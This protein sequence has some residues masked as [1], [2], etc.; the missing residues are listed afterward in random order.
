MANA[1]ITD[2]VVGYWSSGRT[3]T[4]EM[5]EQAMKEWKAQGVS[6]A[7]I[8][9]T[10]MSAYG[11]HQYQQRSEAALA[12]DAKRPQ[13]VA[14][15]RAQ[16]YD[17]A[18]INDMLERQELQEVRGISGEE[19]ERLAQASQPQKDPRAI[20]NETARL[21]AMQEA[22]RVKET[23]TEAYKQIYTKEYREKISPRVKKVS[24]K[25][26]AKA[27]DKLITG[28]LSPAQKEEILKEARLIDQGETARAMG[29]PLAA[30]QARWNE[31]KDNSPGYEA[32]AREQIIQL[33]QTGKAYFPGIGDIQLKGTQQPTPTQTITGANLF[34]QMPSQQETARA[35]AAEFIK[36]KKLV[37]GLSTP[38]GYEAITQK[39]ITQ[40]IPREPRTYSQ[41]VIEA[42]AKIEDVEE[43]FKRSVGIPQ[44]GFYPIKGI[45]ESAEKL[46]TFG[47]ETG[48]RL[49]GQFPSPEVSVKTH[50]IEGALTAPQALLELPKF[51]AKT[52]IAD[53]GIR[54]LQKRADAGD[55]KARLELEKGAYS[56]ATQVISTATDPSFYLQTAGMVLLPAVAGKAA[57]RAIRSTA[58][59]GA[60]IITKAGK[61]KVKITPVSELNTATLS[62]IVAEQKIP[63]SKAVKLTA[64]QMRGLEVLSAETKPT[65]ASVEALLTGKAEFATKTYPRIQIGNRVIDL[66][67]LAETKSYKLSD[68]DAIG[69]TFK[70]YQLQRE[71]YGVGEPSLVEGTI[72]SKG[73][74][75]EIIEPYA[76]KEGAKTGKY[77]ARLEKPLE[78]DITGRK[79]KQQFKLPSQRNIDQLLKPETPYRITAEM[80]PQEA[81]ASSQ[82][83]PRSKFLGGKRYVRTISGKTRPTFTEEILGDLAIKKIGGEA[84]L[85]YESTMPETMI[86][87]RIIKGKTT[88]VIKGRAGSLDIGGEIIKKIFPDA[89]ISKPWVEVRKPK[90]FKKPMKP[91]DFGKGTKQIEI[92]K[93]D[94]KDILGTTAKQVETIAKEKAL[95][96]KPA[97]QKTIE[98]ISTRAK[99]GGRNILNDINMAYTQLSGKAIPTRKGYQP[100][101]MRMA[102]PTTIILPSSKDIQILK[103]SQ[104]T[105][106][107]QKQKGTQIQ[108]QPQ[109]KTQLSRQR[110][111]ITEQEKTLQTIIG[112]N[113]IRQT[114][115]P[116]DEEPPA[117]EPP[118]PPIL[119]VL[120]PSL[121]FGFGPSKRSSKTPSGKAKRT[122]TPDLTSVIKNIKIPSIKTSRVLSGVGIRGIYEPKKKRVKRGARN[123]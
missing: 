11:Q 100:T 15:L 29:V 108:R 123:R 70:K 53:A 32:K 101:N 98:K 18:Q 57:P 43:R 92:T 14:E 9:Q 47:Q 28:D 93:T 2:V 56:S 114:S 90:Q 46:A 118:P 78:F 35:E 24:Y 97:Y 112:T 13:L 26:Q 21:E 119:P 89:P 83:S 116:P 40:P 66:K 37:Y 33:E 12:W 110:Q 73:T 5:L 20:I 75:R 69:K 88:G 82:I 63:A 122:Y 105:I 49:R 103:Q 62:K 4:P 42:G 121:L 104:S 86:R 44:L 106:P 6:E 64:D 3:P 50:L 115:Q 84:S 71:P 7:Q 91:F 22:K 102:S 36:D 55:A 58:V 54:E 61:G 94:V 8:A 72:S 85:L 109:R 113:I 30:V 17:T 34:T 31:Y 81:I 120:N 68:L 39:K 65:P 41:R 74:L 79:P 111:R 96:E 76:L 52:I 25:G 1:P 60:N 95:S 16:G 87:G 59:R 38:E 77:T 51:A 10:R 67:Q 80:K 27:Y 117:D 19:Y 23:D 99:R 48:S 107:Q 45:Y